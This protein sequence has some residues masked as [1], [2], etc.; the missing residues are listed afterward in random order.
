MSPCNQPPDL[1]RKALKYV[2]T[3]IRYFKIVAR[4]PFVK[5]NC[6][7]A[8]FILTFYINYS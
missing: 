5:I 4:M 7:I 3:T 6:C 1:S 2:R 8:I